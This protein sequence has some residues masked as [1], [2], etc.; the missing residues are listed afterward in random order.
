[1]FS[2]EG[3]NQLK[4]YY[5]TDIDEIN[6]LTEGLQATDM[7]KFLGSFED[8]AKGVS[9]VKGYKSIPKRKW[10]KGIGFWSNIM[11][12]LADYRGFVAPR[13]EALKN[14]LN[15]LD[16]EIYTRDFKLDSEEN[17]KLE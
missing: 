14:Q 17:L 3:L 9:S 8:Y 1:L 13:V 16:A 6:A 10:N 2:E 11:A 15:E 12:E 7:G 4:D 5:E